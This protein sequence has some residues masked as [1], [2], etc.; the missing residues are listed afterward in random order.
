MLAIDNRHCVMLLLLD[1]SAAFDTVD[2]VILLKRLNS[3]FS[4]R[5]TALDW[6]RSYLTR[7]LEQWEFVGEDDVEENQEYKEDEEEE[8]NEEDDNEEEEEEEGKEEENREGEGASVPTDLCM[9]CITRPRNESFIH[10]HTGHQVCCFQ[11]ASRLKIEKERCPVCQKKIKLVNK[12][13]V[14]DS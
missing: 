7:E 14:S 10:G 4:I 1:L 12:K 3:K 9:I 6:F 11:C 8:E 5:G 2:H 13:F